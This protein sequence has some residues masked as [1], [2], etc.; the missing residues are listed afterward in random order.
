[1]A[2]MPISIFLFLGY[3]RGASSPTLTKRLSVEWR[4][5][6]DFVVEE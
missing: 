3:A 1:M 4:A 5:T 2:V 6:L